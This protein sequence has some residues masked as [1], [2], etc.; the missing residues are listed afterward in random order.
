MTE[1]DVVVEES[2][3]KDLIS[4]FSYIAEILLEP[5][6][7]NRVFRVI[8]EKLLDLAYMPERHQT[9]TEE[10]YASWGIRKLPVE[11][12]TVFYSIYEES[13]E[14]HIIRVLYNRR[15]WQTLI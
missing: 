11:N 10:P 15:E 13:R 2:A 4:I 9:I 14:V 6:T 8:S 12:Y 5:S 7:A 1:Y 3:E